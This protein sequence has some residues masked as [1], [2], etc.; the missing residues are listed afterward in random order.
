MPIASITKEEKLDVLLQDMRDFCNRNKERYDRIF[1]EGTDDIELH[2][3][4]GFF[5]SFMGTFPADMVVEY[6]QGGET[7]VGDLLARAQAAVQAESLRDRLFSAYND[8]DDP[9]SPT[10]WGPDSLSCRRWER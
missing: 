4:V 6:L 10:K 8:W 5:D 7:K 9:T 2:D 1:P 3:L